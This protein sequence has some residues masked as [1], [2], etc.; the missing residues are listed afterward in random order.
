MGEG[1]VGSRRQVQLELDE[2]GDTRQSWMEMMVCGLR[3]TGS[4]SSKSRQ[5]TNHSDTE[6]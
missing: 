1:N 3:S 4:K 2:G 6:R 5:S